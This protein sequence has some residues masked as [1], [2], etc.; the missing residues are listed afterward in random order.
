MKKLT[1]SACRTLLKR[2]FGGVLKSGRHS[3]DGEVCV[4]EFRSFALGLPWSD[5]PDGA[6]AS[7]TDRICQ[8]LNDAPWSSDQVR[9]EAC[10]PL[11]LL[12]EETAAAGWTA[13]LALRTI[14]E[15]VP[16]ALRTAAGAKGMPAESKAELE[17]HAVA[18]AEMTD[19]K[20]ASVAAG[21]ASDAAWAARAAAGADSAAAGADS[22]A[23]WAARDDVLRRAVTLLIECHT[24]GQP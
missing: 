14:Q 22:A 10:L 7:P 8:E 23:A 6:S 19:L 18:C 20:A 12:S 24:G 13:R 15:I 11:A 21:V 3:Q 1:L 16:L 2:R 4:R 9:A 5:H 17:R